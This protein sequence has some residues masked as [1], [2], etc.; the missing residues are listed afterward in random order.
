MHS[1]TP[2]IYSSFGL[3]PNRGAI[4][5]TDPHGGQAFSYAGCRSCCD[6]PHL[7]ELEMGPLGVLDIGTQ[8]P[9]SNKRDGNH[10]NPGL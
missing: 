9:G 3:H 10:P 7:P 4:G 8:F 6:P 1:S 2:E 5:D